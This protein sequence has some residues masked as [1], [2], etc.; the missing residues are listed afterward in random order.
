MNKLS[1]FFPIA[2]ALAQY[3]SSL[4]KSDLIAG[5]TVGVMLV[6]QGMAYA[7]LA[8]M[9]PIYG[10]YSG[11]IPLLIYALLGTSRQMSI[12]PVA[13][14]SLLVL[15]GVGQLAEPG[16]ADYVSYVVMA[17]LLIGIGQAALGVFRLGFLVNFLSQPVL[18]GFTTAA[19]I[20]IAVSQLKDFLGFYIPRFSKSYETFFYAMNHL[21]ETNWISVVMCLSAMGL[22]LLLKKINNNLPGALIV[23]ILGTLVVW[24]FRLD[25]YGLGIIKTVPEGLPAFEMPLLEMGRIQALLPTILTV[26]IIGIVESMSIAKVMEAK[27][28][29]YTIRP[30]QELIAIGAA[31]IGGAF[32]Q[33]I[34]T[35]GSFTRSA[36]N[37]D[38]GAKSGI[39]SLVTMLLIVLTLLFLTPLF[40]YLPKAVLAAIILLAVK[41]LFE[42]KEAIYLWKN[43][44]QDFVMMV[45][46]FVV[47]LGLGI[48]IGV[49]AGVLLSLLAVLYRT[50]KP[51]V[52][53]LGQLPDSTTYRNLE[54]FPA[55]KTKEDVV[56][57]RFDEQLYFGN[58]TYFKDIIKRKVA[59]KN[60]RLF[61]LDGSAINDIDGS[62]LHAL[63]EI[64]GYLKSRGILFHVSGL[65]GP[66]RDRVASAGL[67]ELI[68]EE[69]FFQ[70]VHDA[71]V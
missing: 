61:L 58:A 56:I 38:A 44:R 67:V 71:V 35:S 45:L 20:V 65:L 28:Q 55:A 68:G 59:E 48:K 10:L 9:P 42:Y 26:T 40:Y 50:S 6:P 22:I 27:N 5:L 32:F 54:R 64:H 21:A 47:T 34:P 41:G 33:S 60:P 46:T 70:R 25:E 69:C 31:K 53:I 66:V 23:V 62:G 13:V 52:A 14:S 30:N 63:E 1:K 4:F 49:A 15:A 2:E 18:A 39:A 7:F 3:N 29:N 36:I 11:L 16:S 24:F 51:H 8:G 43:H 12:G 37:N 17:G 19:A 57:L